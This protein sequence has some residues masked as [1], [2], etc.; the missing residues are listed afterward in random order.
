MQYEWQF[1]MNKC[2]ILI[3]LFAVS[4]VF[5]AFVLLCQRLR[6]KYVR[7]FWP[8]ID[9][10][11]G[12]ILL[13]Y[14]LLTGFIYFGGGG[15][16]QCCVGSNRGCQS[17]RKCNRSLWKLLLIFRSK[18]EM[19]FWKLEVVFRSFVSHSKP[20]DSLEPGLELAHPWKKPLALPLQIQ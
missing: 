18:L 7:K 14:W 20:V 3:F 1:W 16:F 9:Y 12:V 11:Y 13:V 10:I 15:L 19:T 8:M 5:L 17:L 6:K 2:I 4:L